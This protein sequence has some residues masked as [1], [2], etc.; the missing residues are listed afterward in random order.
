MLGDDAVEDEACLATSW[1][2]LL[3]MGFLHQ[4]LARSMRDILCKL[5][6][7]QFDMAYSFSFFLH[8]HALLCCIMHLNLDLIH[9][10]KTTYFVLH[11]TLFQ[12]NIN[13]CI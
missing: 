12:K 4:F 10:I 5:T 11:L 9:E 1:W 3:S 6:C 2:Q 8:V 7:N 13:N